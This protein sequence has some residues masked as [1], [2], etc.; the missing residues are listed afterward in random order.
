MPQATPQSAPS[1]PPSSAPSKAPRPLR[2]PTGS[3]TPR[4]RQ[5]ALAH[6]RSLLPLIHKRLRSLDAHSICLLASDAFFALGIQ[7]PIEW[8]GQSSW[9]AES[10]LRTLYPQDPATLFPSF[11][12]T[13]VELACYRKPDVDTAC[14]HLLSVAATFL[15]HHLATSE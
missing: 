4:R 8:Y 13:L 15:I 3:S 11:E 14:Q 1:A 7:D 12:A 10:L 2:R 5:E 9:L 6:T